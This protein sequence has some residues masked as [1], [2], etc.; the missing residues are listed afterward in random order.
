MPPSDKTTMLK[1]AVISIL[2]VA[3]MSQMAAAPVGAASES[4]RPDAFIKLCGVNVGCLIDGLP[5]PWVGKNIYN[6]TGRHQKIH[7]RLDNGRG[8]RFW[9][10]FRN[11]GTQTDTYT[12]DGC[13]GNKN[14]QILQVLVGKFKVP[15][16]VDAEHIDYQFKHDSWTFKLKPGKQIAI[17]LNI[18]TVDRKDLGLTYRCPMTVTSQ[19]DATKQDTVVAIMTTY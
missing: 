12:L 6:T 16:G 11:D 10:T 5:H 13:T 15:I 18:L 1:R 2:A 9:I 8:I 4:Y 7:H 14:F 17:T 19:G 3:A